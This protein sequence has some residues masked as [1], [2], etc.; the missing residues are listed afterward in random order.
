MNNEGQITKA[1]TSQRLAQRQ[2]AVSENTGEFSFVIGGIFIYIL[3][4]I[5]FFIFVLFILYVMKDTRLFKKNVKNECT[6]N[7]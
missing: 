6:T 5:L 1:Y 2:I 7:I 4:L 3:A